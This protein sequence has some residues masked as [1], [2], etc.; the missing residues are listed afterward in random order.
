ME[1]VNGNECLRVAL[2]I[3]VL[4]PFDSCPFEKKTWWFHI[5][6]SPPGEVG[7]SGATAG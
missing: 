7:H 3:E 2:S 4:S 1:N 6:Y 5:V